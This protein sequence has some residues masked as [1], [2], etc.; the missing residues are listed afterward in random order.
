MHIG[1]RLVLVSALAIA[2]CGVQEA[3]VGSSAEDV[4]AFPEAGQ[5]VFWQKGVAPATS[6]SNLIDHGGE[7]LPASNTY[8]IWWGNAS[9]WPS[10]VQ[11]GLD[12]LFNG[13]NGSNFLVDIATQYMRGVSVG[14]SF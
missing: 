1:G 4:Q 14:S 6:T 5:R 3:D 11:G 7:V 13:L 2:G 10:D 8:A 12:S 9:A